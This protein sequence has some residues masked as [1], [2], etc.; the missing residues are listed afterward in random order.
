MLFIISAPS[1]AGKTTLCRE[2]VKTVP[3]LKP[4]VSY[5]TRPPRRGEKNNVHYTFVSESRFKRMIEKGEFAEWAVVH[6]NLYGTSIKRLDRI[7]RE[8]YD[9]ILDIDIHGA[10]Q[11]R[12]R[13]RGSVGIFILPP[14]MDALRERLMARMSES[15]DEM[16]RRLDRAREE[17]LAYKDYDYVVINDDFKKALRELEGII[18]ST[19]LATSRFDQS[20][21]DMLMKEEI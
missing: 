15:D 4:S 8:G 11:L 9:I 20:F 19:R 21:I 2:L 1:G 17:I 18:I 3:S 6:G 10:M 16:R 7:K 12:R 5:T 13:Y 14:S